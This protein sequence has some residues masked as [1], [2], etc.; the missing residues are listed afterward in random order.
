MPSIN[1]YLKLQQIVNNNKIPLVITFLFDAKYILPNCER[2]APVVAVSFHLPYMY[3]LLWIYCA[4][5][6]H[7]WQKVV[8]HT[9][10]RW[11]VFFSP[12]RRQAITWTNTGLLSIGLMGT[13]FNE[14]WIGILSFLF[15]KMPWKISS[16]KMAAILSRGRSVNHKLL[17]CHLA[18]GMQHWTFL[19]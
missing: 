19:Q 4:V 12:V 1:S 2:S 8:H 7:K 3:N 14:I 10:L 16:A 6:M 17:Q 5:G 13:Y 15:K 18:A 9:Q 11:T